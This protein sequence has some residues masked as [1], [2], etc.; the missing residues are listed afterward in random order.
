MI[1]KVS[2]LAAYVRSQNRARWSQCTDG[3]AS[4][5][6]QTTGDLPAMQAVIGHA[7]WKAIAGCNLKQALQRFRQ[8][9]LLTAGLTHFSLLFDNA[10][11]SCHGTGLS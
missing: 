1:C 9:A 2:L 5:G 11:Y 10:E 6:I 4:S 7:V 8:L 3:R